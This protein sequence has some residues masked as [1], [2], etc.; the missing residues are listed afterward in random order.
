MKTDLVKNLLLRH[1]LNFLIEVFIR[2]DVRSLGRCLQVSETWRDFIL[3]YLLG[4]HRRRI[5]RRAWTELSSEPFEDQQTTLGGS[6]SD[7]SSVGEDVYVSFTNGQCQKIGENNQLEDLWANTELPHIV[8]CSSKVK[9]NKELEMLEI[10]GR[11][12]EKDEVSTTVLVKWRDSD[13]VIYKVEITQETVTALLCENSIFIRQK[14]CE[15]YSMLYFSIQTFRLCPG[16][17]VGV[18]TRV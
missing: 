13:Q 18:Q 16:G 2:L 17:G 1:Q 9:V 14:S 10:H 3:H 4:G 12:R 6:I 7:V 11:S 5:L 15:G 8:T